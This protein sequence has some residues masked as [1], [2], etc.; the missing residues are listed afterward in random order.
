MY[1]DIWN[2]GNGILTF[3]FGVTVN[4]VFVVCF[5]SV[6]VLHNLSRRSEHYQYFYIHLFCPISGCYFPVVYNFVLRKIMP[7]VIKTNSE[8]LFSVFWLSE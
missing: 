2:L 6:S 4:V 7:I 8:E 5:S 1:H 3:S